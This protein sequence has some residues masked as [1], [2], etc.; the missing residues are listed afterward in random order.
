[1]IAGIIRPWSGDIW[2]DGQRLTDIP[3]H[4]L[5]NTVAVV[6]QNIS[7]FEGTVAENITMW[8]ATLPEARMVEAARDAGLHDEIAARPGGYRELIE[9]GG[10]NFSGGERQRIEIARALVTE[11]S[12]LLLD[13]ATSALDARTESQIMRNLRRRGQTCVLIAHRLSTIRD[14]DEILVLEQGHVVERGHHDAL[15]AMDGAYRKLVES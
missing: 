13:E 6:D 4:V 14:C 5:R 10:R 9:E 3:R 7:L 1:M 12:I 8:D 2:I 11:P 15:L